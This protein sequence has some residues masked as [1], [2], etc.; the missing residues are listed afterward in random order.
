MGTAVVDQN[1][2]ARG[3]AIAHQLITQEA[4]HMGTL[5]NKR[6][7]HADAIPTIPGPAQRL[8]FSGRTSSGGAKSIERVHDNN[9]I[10]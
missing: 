6:R 10:N 8:S 2:I 1:N 3:G 7:G 5:C 4:N 9:P